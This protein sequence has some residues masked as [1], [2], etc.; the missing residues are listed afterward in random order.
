MK[1]STKIDKNLESA[2][3]IKAWKYHIMLI[4]EKNDVE[5]FIKEELEEPKE[6]EDKSKYKKDMIKAKRII[7][8][9]IKYNLILQVYLGRT[10]KEMFDA[11]SSL[12]KEET[13]IER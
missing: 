1:K 3:N 5:G 12:L 2:E 4:L 8:E 10:P 11:L 9:S 6:A 13:S 7:D